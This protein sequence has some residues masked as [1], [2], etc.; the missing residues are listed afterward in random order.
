MKKPLQN[1]LKSYSALAS[2][3]AAT[4]AVNA[5]I[6]YTD[7]SPDVTVN[8]T[9]SGVN[10][11]LDNG[12]FVDFIVAEQ[13]GVASSMYAY[14]EVLTVVPQNGVNAVA[15][16]GTIGGVYPLNSVLNLNDP[17]DAALTWA[18]DT[19]QFAA[20]VYPASTSYN[21]G[22]WVGATDKYFGFRFNLGGNTHYGWARFDVSTDGASFTLKDYA[23][24]A[25]PNTMIPAGAMP[26]STDINE[27]LANTTNIYGFD[28]SINVKLAAGTSIDG[29]I[30]VTDI[31]G[32]E[33]HKVNVADETTTIAMDD[34][35]SGMYI[36]NITKA[37]GSSYS[38]KL[39]MK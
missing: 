20:R 13:T 4:G 10:I 37:N 29:V 25:T 35:K 16:N 8:T 19:V 31:L 7:V 5:Q 26:V 15:Q 18:T 1:K 17:I 14:N 2:A 28:K 32:Q 6:V 23:Y 36:V 3:V 22:N 21:F 33:V 24:D 27:Q 30:T 39:F 11:D 9:L 12:G 38:K 34:A